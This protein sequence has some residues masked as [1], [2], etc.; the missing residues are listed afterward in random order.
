MREAP[1][2]M[3]RKG[4][5][6]ILNGVG[7]AGKSSIA[8]ALQTI[9]PTPWLHIEMDKFCEMLPARYQDH[10]DGFAYETKEA[11]GQPIVI[12]GE[13][14]YGA[15]LI[16]GMRRAIAAMAEE[17][18][19]LIVDDV[20]WGEARADYDALLEGFEVFWV[21]VMAPLE[22]LEERER[23]RSDRLIG[24]SRGQMARVHEGQRYD[25]E[26]DTSRMTAMECA[27]AIKRAIGF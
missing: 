27:E 16:R 2:F 17:G 6:I 3:T 10:P 25:L 9:L 5:L 7:S 13:G 11:D 22:L 15:R 1:S 12:I 18:N 26:V 14:P 23:Q 20:M 4:R 21:G 24:T 8:K 19:D